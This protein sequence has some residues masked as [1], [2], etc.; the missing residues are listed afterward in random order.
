MVLDRDPWTVQPSTLRTTVVLAT[1]LD[2][3]PV[4]CG[5]GFCERSDAP[6]LTVQARAAIAER[7]G[8]RQQAG[9]QADA[10][11]DLPKALVFP[12]RVLQNIPRR[13]KDCN[14]RVCVSVRKRYRY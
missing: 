3:V 5:A 13:R 10:L 12:G 7:Q 14:C 9:F 8:R 4:Y 11:M 6:A 1:Y 2:G